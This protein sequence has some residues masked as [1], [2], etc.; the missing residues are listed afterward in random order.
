M[1]ESIRSAWVSRLHGLLTVILAVL[2]ILIGIQHFVDPATFM[3]IVPDWLP[4][5]RALVL[6][7][8]FFEIAGG[9]G[10]LLL[11]TR[12]AASF[13]L[14][15]LYI[16]VFPANVHMAIHGI[17]LDPHNPMPEWAMWLRLPMQGLVIAWAWW[18][19]RF[20]S[21]VRVAKRGVSK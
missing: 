20:V 17:Q 12:R 2:M 11:R 8:G 3:L 18:A 1:K 4:A 16:A 13:G 15:A 5:P 14:I 10:L 19:G 7:S 9:V 6:I 21:S